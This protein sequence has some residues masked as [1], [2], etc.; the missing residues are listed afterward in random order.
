MPILR[1][2]KKPYQDAGLKIISSP[3]LLLSNETN[4]LINVELAGTE[5]D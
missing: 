2:A 5:S 1:W 4:N 3:R